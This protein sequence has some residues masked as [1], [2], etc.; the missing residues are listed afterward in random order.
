MLCQLPL[1]HSYKRLE[2]HINPEPAPGH[3]HQGGI[4]ISRGS[5]MLLSAPQ[6]VCV[7]VCVL[8]GGGGGERAICD[9]EHLLKWGIAVLFALFY[10]FHFRFRNPSH[11]ARRRKVGKWGAQQLE[12]PQIPHW[13]RY[14]LL[15]SFIVFPF[16]QLRF[17]L[18]IQLS[19]SGMTYSIIGIF[20][21]GKSY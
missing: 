4:W 19:N 11:S 5:Q 9:R 6:S 1:Y 2:K 17:M 13:R 20:W 15:Q 8:G 18:V 12:C 7:C 3:L 10:R 14:T 21:H 16:H